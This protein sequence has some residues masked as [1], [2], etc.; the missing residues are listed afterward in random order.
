LL[1]SLIH[2]AAFASRAARGSN[3]PH[4]ER[5]AGAGNLDL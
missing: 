1:S 2:E 5:R 3:A 4:L